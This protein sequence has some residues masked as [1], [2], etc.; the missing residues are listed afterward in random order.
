MK[1]LIDL[2]AKT[3]VDADRAIALLSILS[4]YIQV[5]KTGS[6]DKLIIGTPDSYIE[7]GETISFVSEGERI[8]LLNLQKLED[9]VISQLPDKEDGTDEFIDGREEELIPFVDEEE[10]DPVPEVK[11][12]EVRVVT[13]TEMRTRNV[14][15]GGRQRRSGWVKR[16]LHQIYPNNSTFCR[17][18]RII[19]GVFFN[20]FYL[21]KGQYSVIARVPSAFGDANQSRLY[22][23][24]TNEAWVGSSIQSHGKVE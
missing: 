9:W 23:H 24:N 5:E 4:D 1:K 16:S 19:F 11:E 10:I 8:G 13:I 15:A 21:T 18:G 14:S 12:P 2:L 17:E 3:S 6:G 7:I 22:N 20:D